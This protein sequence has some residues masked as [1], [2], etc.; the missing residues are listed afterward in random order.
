MTHQICKFLLLKN[1][2]TV[3]KEF[4]KLLL[5][6]IIIKIDIYKKNLNTKNFYILQNY[7]V[8]FMIV[9]LNLKSN[10]NFILYC[11]GTNFFTK[12]VK[13]INTISEKKKLLNILNNLFLHEFT[14][15]FFRNERDENLENL[16]I[17]ENTEFSK[18]SLDID[19][20]YSPTEY[21]N[22]FKYLSTFSISYDNFFN[23]V[24]IED[25]ERSYYKL[26]ISQSIIR[27]TFS[28]EKRKY[29]ENI[30]NFEFELLKTLVEKNMKETFKKFKDNY[31]TLFRKDDL[32]DDILKYMFFIFGNSMIIESYLKPV[33]KL[34][35]Y[36]KDLVRNITLQEY[37][38]IIEEFITN[39]TKTI[40]LVLKVLLKLVYIGVRK[41]FTIEEKNYGPLFTLLFF[42]FLINPRVQMIYNINPIECNYIK[43]LNRL[44]YA[45]IYNSKIKEEGYDD[46]K[47]YIHIYHEKLEK[48]MFENIIQLNEEDDKIKESLSNLF[49]E[50]Y[51]TYPEFL[52]FKDTEF[53]CSSILGGKKVVMDY[54]KIAI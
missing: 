46:Y 32:Y 44:I 47:Q 26:L 33:K 18:N 9:T 30:K 20:R 15:I 52:I 39:I 50:K 6:E 1:D 22:I 23:N 12:V 35:D 31:K 10:K 43:N 53:L 51:L 3:F 54:Q 16:Y 11:F 14:E 29:V 7:I 17:I 28:K 48:F 24:N 40:P 49:T 42:N 41:Y 37:I 5:K 25:D 45:T 38:T 27:L 13:E 21:K 4:F 8:F 19:A 36:E 34:I 2:E